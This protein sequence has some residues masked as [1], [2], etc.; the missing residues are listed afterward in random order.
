MT[1]NPTQETAVRECGIQLVLAGPGSGKT[2]VITEK[3][4][5]LVS[6]GIAPDHI[7]AL[8]FSEKAAQEMLD[9][10]EG[11]VNTAHLFVGTFHAFCLE[12]LQD[13]ILDSGISFHGGV[14]S[15]A[16]Q[17]VWG[18]AHIDEFG[19]SHIEVGN[20]APGVIE[21]IIDGISAFRDELITP[22]ELERFLAA[23]EDADV[24][25][26]EREY[27]DKLSDLLKV[28]RSYEKYK[29][30]AN[31]LD[32]D[33]M[34]HEAVRLFETKPH[35]LRRYRSQYTHILVDEFQDTN[36][37]QAQLIRLLAGENVCVVGDDDQTIYRFRGAYLTNFRD[38]REHYTACNEILLSHNYRNTQ[39]ILSLALELMKH[40]PNRQEKELLTQ[41]PLGD[42][43]VVAECET[44][45]AEVTFVLSEIQRLLGTP[46]S[47]KGESR[48]FVP[49]DFAII[50]RRRAEGVKYY[51]AL[52][53]LGIPVEF[54][55]E[56]EFFSARVI[57]DLLAYLTVTANPLVAGVPL[58]RIMKLAGVSEPS[59]QKINTAAREVARAQV[60]NDGVYESMLRAGEIVLSEA[61]VIR[62]VTEVIERL[63]I[64]KDQV[65]LHELV[66]GL[67]MRDTNLYQRA[68]AD[69][70]QQ[71]P[72]LL[73]TFLTITQEYESIAPDTAFSGFLEYCH[74]LSGFSVEVGEQE[75]RDAVRVLTAHKSKGKEFPVVFITDLAYG[76]FPLRYQSKPFYVPN[77]LSK[78]LK[79]GDDEKK[80]FEQEERRL[81]YVA[82]TRAES[83][84]YFTRAL[85]YGEN[86]RETKPSQFLI[87]LRYASNPLIQRVRVPAPVMIEESSESSPL[88]DLRRQIR[89]QAKAAIDQ[90]QLQ[91]A[92]QRLVE[93]EKL[94]LI[95][96]GDPPAAFAP[97]AF[98]TY[99]EP[100]FNLAE[101]AKG[102]PLPLIHESHTFSASA[103]NMYADCPLRYKFQYVLLVPSSPRTYFSFGQ[104][105]HRVIEQLSKDRIYGM[106]VTKERALA[107]LNAEWDSSAYPS[108]TQESEDRRK[109]EVLLDT[110][111]TWQKKNNNK[112][113]E[114]EQRFQYRLNGRVIKGYIDRI[115]QQLDG[116]LVVID[117]KSGSSK[118]A[119]ITKNSIREDIQM[120][121]YSIAVQ[122]IYGKLP[123]RASLYYLS[124]NKMIDYIPDEE[125]I[126]AFK[127]RVQGMIASVCAEEFVA[128]P[129]YMGCQRC[130]YV[131]LCEMGERG[132]NLYV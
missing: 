58:A 104:A 105:V 121:L 53:H 21:S 70:E 85:K 28:Y 67:V 110:F 8:T 60:A 65:T 106:L 44:E 38:F 47:S 95:E 54:V 80:L 72:L 22:D 127:E 100:D 76:R 26:A 17:L 109:A 98:F 61:P 18:L 33:D 41:N 131:D 45:Q 71:E 108:K 112:I 113:I 36:Y 62:E 66:H 35:I 101:L 99:T 52:K 111:L 118:S 50:C 89:E 63:L 73:R 34:I 75:N 56:V 5:H 120:N 82:M 12:I 79:T 122:E 86:K 7:L 126:A 9:R 132:S 25:D 81:C 125:N 30:S 90:L 119:G 46:C 92:L 77:D 78:G 64:A 16:N 128:K 4:L 68:L 27:L 93:L 1:L 96:K 19:F 6:Q 11:N 130:D 39:T 15:R 3:I 129:S 124:D 48:V 40:A 43:A 42:P 51:R 74:L 102:K 55:G 115:E 10:L 20:N 117:F 84:L 32:Y 59:I 97:Q 23:K 116:G 103:L 37:A 88:E 24:P 87:E 49:G 57:R 31:L 13:N 123:V 91:T 29:R 83:R 107:L 94:R 69:E 2:R 114:A 14:I